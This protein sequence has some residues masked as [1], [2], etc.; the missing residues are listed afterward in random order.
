MCDDFRCL[1]AMKE[2]R[3][4]LET[5]RR[6]VLSFCRK[7]N[8]LA[9]LT[10]KKPSRKLHTTDFFLGLQVLPTVSST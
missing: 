1:Y 5:L 10:L 7:N 9:L 8:F 2:R 6:F 4:T 3:T